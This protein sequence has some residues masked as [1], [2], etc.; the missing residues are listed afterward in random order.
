MYLQRHQL[1]MKLRGDFQKEVM[2]AP[3]LV[4][5]DGGWE[6][7]NRNFCQNSK[8]L[9]NKIIHPN[10]PHQII[11]CCHCSGGDEEGTQYQ[12]VIKENKVYECTA[13]HLGVI[14]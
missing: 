7:S 10:N 12:L 8:E 2:L 3:F 13:G 11:E 14:Y 4:G 9:Q 5:K 6:Q 1:T